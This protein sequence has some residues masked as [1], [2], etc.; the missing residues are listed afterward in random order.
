V[1]CVVYVAGDDNLCYVI[2]VRNNRHI[3][4]NICKICIHYGLT[5]VAT[6]L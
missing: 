6:D 1:S 3:Y 5:D 4:K 2:A